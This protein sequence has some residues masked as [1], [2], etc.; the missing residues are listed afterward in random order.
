MTERLDDNNDRWD[1]RKRALR[2]GV[3]RRFRKLRAPATP[4][5]CLFCDFEGHHAGDDGER[6]A[7]AGTARLLQILD[8][9]GL[10]ITFNIVADL[11]ETQHER[12]EHVRDAG[13]EIACHGWHNE[14]PRSLT[15]DQT[16][17][18]L[19]NA[20]SAFE[21]LKIVPRGFRSP[22]S[23]WTNTLVRYLPHYHFEWNAESDRSWRPYRICDLMA[24]MAVKSDDRGLVDGTTNSAT[25]LQNWRSV[26]SETKSRRG[27]VAVGLHEWII[28]KDRE[29][30]ENLATFITEF[31][32][33][34]SIRIAGIGDAL[35]EIA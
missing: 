20:V 15:G 24:R 14:S 25:L 34:P 11:C 18:M 21:R 8:D 31:R 29:F 3:G 12:V 28:G 32:A 35:R 7:D 5:I 16:I 30:A 17:E 9:T 22:Q 26:A 13:H 4:T 27:C 10:R 23:A 1:R 6:F 19:Q 2:A 33:D